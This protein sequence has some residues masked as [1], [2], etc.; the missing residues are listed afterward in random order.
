[1]SNDRTEKL[2]DLSENQHEILTESKCDT[3]E[4]IS[5]L[6]NYEN[7]ESFSVDPAFGADHTVTQRLL[8]AMQAPVGN[9]SDSIEANSSL[10]LVPLNFEPLRD[11]VVENGL[12]DQ[13]PLGL[14][15]RLRIELKMIGL[16]DVDEA[17]V[18]RSSRLHVR[19]DSSVL[20]GRRFTRRA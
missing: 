9:G 6:S 1:M 4:Q 11:P 10:P 16:L 5:K 15:D 8:S 3:R 20:L 18:S 13:T 2:D 14:E 7:F 17:E 12:V 19:T